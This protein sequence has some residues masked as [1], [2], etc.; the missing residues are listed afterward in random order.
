[1]ALDVQLSVDEFLH[2]LGSPRLPIPEGCEAEAE[3]AC[4]ALAG[5]VEPLRR[6][7]VVLGP[8]IARLYGDGPPPGGAAQ[9][10]KKPARA[11]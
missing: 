11:A 1:M 4:V 7:Q 3:A 2:R 8:H 9:R 10:M 6:L 5:T